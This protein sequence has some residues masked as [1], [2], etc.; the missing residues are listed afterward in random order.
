[1]DKKQKLEK[2][3]EMVKN[4]LVKNLGIIITDLGD[5]FICGKMPVNKGTIQ[6][7]GL[8]HGGASCC[9]C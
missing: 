1:M 2:I 8:L 9:P 6:P 7:Y 5:S 3:N 4:T